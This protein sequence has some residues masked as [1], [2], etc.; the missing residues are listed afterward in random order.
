M[1]K[2]WMSLL[3]TGL[4]GMAQAAMVN[5]SITGAAGDNWSGQF[6]VQSL[7]VT[8][9][10]WLQENVLSFSANGWETI[11]A[12]ADDTLFYV[13]SSSGGFLQWVNYDFGTGPTYGLTLYSS[14][15]YTDLVA[16]SWGTTWNALI[17]KSYAIDTGEDKQTTFLGPEGSLTSTGGQ[18]SFSMSAVPEVSSSFTLLGLF[19]SGLMLRRRAK[20]LR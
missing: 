17:G 20:S 2:C 4:C 19:T 16:N 7:D 3:M 12:S 11:L 13:G 5:Y 1:K 8:P 15:L 14:A 9:S 10:D 6:E 18:I